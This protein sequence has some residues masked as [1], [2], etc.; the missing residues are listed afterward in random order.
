MMTQRY[1]NPQREDC[2]RPTPKPAVNQPGCLFAA[3]SKTE[4]NFANEA[5]KKKRK[6]YEAIIIKSV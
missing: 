2:K 4:H 6:K 3:L 5:I 1:Y